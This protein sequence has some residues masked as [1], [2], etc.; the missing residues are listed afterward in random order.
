MAASIAAILG[1][2]LGSFMNVCAY[3]LPRGRSLLIPSSCPSCSRRLHWYQLVPVVSFTLCRGRCSSC[4]ARI[5][6]R[7]PIIELSAAAVLVFLFFR[8]GATAHLVLV[9]SYCLL[10]LLIAV[11]DWQHLI[12]PNELVT[13]GLILVALFE[14]WLLPD[15]V[16][17]F[18]ASSL[19]SFGTM[20][21]VLLLGN[22]IFKKETMG[23]GDV[24]LAAVV[25]LA[26]GFLGFLFSLWAAAIT[27][28]LYAAGK[29]MLRA[30][31]PVP[32]LPSAQVP[33]PFGAFL[34][35]TSSLVL[36]FQDEFNDLLASWLFW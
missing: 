21:S 23:M 19:L 28:L 6:W 8:Y 29:T 25:G 35:L 10:M 32:L 14:F 13:L 1:L 4:A 9:Y 11:I 15:H 17:E 24:K 18:L 5:P 16:P 3:R 2:S 33:L 22:W 30:L 34:A 27:S 20:L 31:T 12:I 7:Y 26:V 36:V